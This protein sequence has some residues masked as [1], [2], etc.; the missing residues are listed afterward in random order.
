MD[1][2]RRAASTNPDV[3][4]LVERWDSLTL[5][6][7]TAVTLTD[8]CRACGVTL[9]DF[10]GAAARGCCM[11]GNRCVLIA[12]QRMELPEDV[13]ASVSKWFS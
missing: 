5:A 9:A 6:A 12:L 7:Q 8:L 4:P 2:V 10:I 11:A 3:V 13:E 1:Y